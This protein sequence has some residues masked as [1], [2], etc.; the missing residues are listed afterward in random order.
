MG[1]NEIIQSSASIR[2]NPRPSILR[3]ARG[4]LRWDQDLRR[5]GG[6]GQRPSDRRSRSRRAPGDRCL[7]GETPSAYTVWLSARPGKRYRL[8]AEAESGSTARAPDPAT[9]YPWEPEPR[10][11]DCTNYLGC[12]AQRNAGQSR[13]TSFPPNAFGLYDM[14]GNAA[15]MESWSD[16]RQTPRGYLS[17]TPRRRAAPI[18]RAELR[19]RARVLRGSSFNNRFRATCAQRPASSYEADVRFYTPAA[20][21]CCASMGV[22]R[23][24]AATLD[25]K[26][27]LASRHR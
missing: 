24:G 19:T 6:C 27:A 7:T 14:A 16:Y 20:S 15:E 1:S 9:T 25:R 8:P 13:A 22:R 2:W 12:T 10:Q 18:P 21:A 26:S 11:G 5:P 4:Q 23:S 3:S 17:R